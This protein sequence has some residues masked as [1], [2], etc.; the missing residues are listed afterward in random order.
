MPEWNP[1]NNVKLQ[2][3]LRSYLL[4]HSMILPDDVEYSPII[5][6]V[7][8]LVEDKVVLTIGL[9]PVSNYSVRETEHTDKY[10]RVTDVA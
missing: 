4:E 6:G 7:W 2:E 10:L 3:S 1:K 9:P 8:V 5:D